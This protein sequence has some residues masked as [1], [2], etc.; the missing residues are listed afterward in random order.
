MASIAR[1]TGLSTNLGPRGYPPLSPQFLL[2][3]N[4]EKMDN[5]FD[6]FIKNK[7]F[8]IDLELELNYPFLSDGTDRIEMFR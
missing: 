7:T 3:D 1:G 5:L 4:N 2:L 6:I 8:K